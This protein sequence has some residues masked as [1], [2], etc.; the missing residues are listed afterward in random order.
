MQHA[1][2]GTDQCKDYG[3]LHVFTVTVNGDCN[4]YTIPQCK[5]VGDSGHVALV[6]I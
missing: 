4:L 6:R 1:L 5:S 2:C 3:S